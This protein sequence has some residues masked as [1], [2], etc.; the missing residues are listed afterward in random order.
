[1]PVIKIKISRDKKKRIISFSTSGHSL[2]DRKGEDIVCAGASAIL[3]TAILGL[4][5]YLNLP[6]KVKKGDGFLDVKLLSQPPA[7]A[8]SILEAMK[9]GL[10]RIAEKHPDYIKIEEIS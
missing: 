10:Y 9:L 4:S 6:I 2:Y 1:M 7:E 3:Q 5:E 8:L